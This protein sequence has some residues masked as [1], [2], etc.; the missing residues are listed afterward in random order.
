MTCESLGRPLKDKARAIESF[1]G[2]YKQS[3]VREVVRTHPLVPGGAD[4]HI[5]GLRIACRWI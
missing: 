1:R 4:E 2:G 5:I 3:Q